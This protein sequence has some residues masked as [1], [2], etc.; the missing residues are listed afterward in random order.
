MCVQ[1]DIDLDHGQSF[2]I[3]KFLNKIKQISIQEINKRLSL[4]EIKLFSVVTKTLVNT[5][6]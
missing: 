5:Y 6:C 1:S 3:H 4:H 2:D